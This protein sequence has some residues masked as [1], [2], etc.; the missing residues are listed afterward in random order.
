M[1]KKIKVPKRVVGVKIPKA[2]RR[3]LKDLASTQN[4]RTV[5]TEALVAAAGLLAAQQAQPGSPTRDL[6]EDNAA[7][8]KA[9]VKALAAE[10]RSWAASAGALEDATR[11][12][13]DS[14]RRRSATGAAEPDRQEPP[15]VAQP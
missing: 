5:L 7:R 4:G 14:L 15:P 8:A 1:A 6:I 12:F 13:T 10:P 2:L 3:G 9:K 11:A